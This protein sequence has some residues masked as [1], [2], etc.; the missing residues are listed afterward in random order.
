MYFGEAQTVLDDKGRITIPRRFRQIMDVLGHRVWYLARGFDHSI[1]LFHQDAWDKICAQAGTFPSMNAKALDFRR[2]FF[3][4]VARVEPD[5]QGRLS[6]PPHLRD[7]AQLNKEVA[8]IGVDDHLEVWDREVWRAFQDK[9]EAEF[10]AMAAQLFAGESLSTAA[11]E[12][13]E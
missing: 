10:K 12:G 1:S 11:T 7:H 8:L 4:S 6:I 3:G 9:H 13:G 2:L 5:R